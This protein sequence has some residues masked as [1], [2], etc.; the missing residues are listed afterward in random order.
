MA[1]WD[2]STTVSDP[3][4]L[5]HLLLHLHVVN[6]CLTQ[7]W[8]GKKTVLLEMSAVWRHWWADETTRAVAAKLPL[9]SWTLTGRAGCSVGVPLAEVLVLVVVGGISFALEERVTLKWWFKDAMLNSYRF[10]NTAFHANVPV[11]N[12]NKRHQR[13]YKFFLEEIMLVVLKINWNCFSTV[14]KKRI[15]FIKSWAWKKACTKEGLTNSK[16]TFLLFL[17]LNQRQNTNSDMLNET[18][19]SI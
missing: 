13:K 3:L 18:E 2:Q 11:Q 1:D 4:P 10:S 16:V 8:N 6:A 19:I 15:Y 17:F 5:H 7:L 9:R 14:F 12:L